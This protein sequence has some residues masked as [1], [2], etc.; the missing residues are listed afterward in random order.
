M[1][2][3]PK[4]MFLSHPEVDGLK[5][6]MTEYPYLIAEVHEIKKTRDDLIDAYLEDMA[7]GRYPMSKLPGYYIFL[8]MFSSLEPCNDTGFQQNILNE[9]AGFFLTER[10]EQ[11]IGLYHKCSES[12]KPLKERVEERDAQK[13]NLRPRRNRI[14]KD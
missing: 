12:D 10:V 8:R 2:Q 1:K 14:Q 3:L 7:Q 5:I 11:K 9:M 4:F 13:A 6:I